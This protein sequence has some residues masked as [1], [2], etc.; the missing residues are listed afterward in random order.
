MAS[1]CRVRVV[2]AIERN[3]LSIIGIPSNAFIRPANRHKEVFFGGVQCVVMVTGIGVVQSVNRRIGLFWSFPAFAFIF[4]AG[5]DEKVF[6]II[7]S[8]IE[9][10]AGIRIIETMHHNFRRFLWVGAICSCQQSR[11]PAFYCRQIRNAEWSITILI[12]SILFW[13]FLEDVYCC[14]G[15]ANF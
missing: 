10:L 7:R 8:R 3:R 13:K 4:P 9:M 12:P 1:C 2:L 5:R 15:I 6:L 11:F 14:L